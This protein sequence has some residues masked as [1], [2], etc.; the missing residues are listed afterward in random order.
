MLAG[1]TSRPVAAEFSFLVGIPTMFA[2]TAL[3]GFTLYRSGQMAHEDWS[4]L[5]VGFVVSSIVAFVAVKWLLNY[6]QTHRF[7]MFGWYRLVVGVALILL[8]R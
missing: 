5:A 6:L 1:M 8:V 4:Q 7:T 3:E 2:A